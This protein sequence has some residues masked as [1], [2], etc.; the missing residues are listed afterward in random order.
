MS[1]DEN[2]YIIKKELLEAVNINLRNCNVNLVKR[3]RSFADKTVQLVDF[4]SRSSGD[5]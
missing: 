3:I 2:P 4:I 5:V 1:F